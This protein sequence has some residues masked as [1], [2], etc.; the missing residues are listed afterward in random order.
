MWA[1]F[2]LVGGVQG[3]GRSS[4][5][6]VELRLV[7]GE[8]RNVG[9]VQACGWSSSLWVESSGLQVEFRDVGGDAPQSLVPGSET[10]HL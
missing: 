9:G 6:W 7:G 4:G 3:C 1:E 10:K 8:F 2:R 5:L